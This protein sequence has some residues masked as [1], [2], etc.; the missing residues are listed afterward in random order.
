MCNLFTR[1]RSSWS[2]TQAHATVFVK[3][4]P[5]RHT[6]EVSTLAVGENIAK[7]VSNRLLRKF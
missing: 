5:F 1:E 4:A 3:R 6:L 2:I 7:K